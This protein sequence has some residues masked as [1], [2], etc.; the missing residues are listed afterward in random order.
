MAAS[1]DHNRERDADRQRI[2]IGVS[3]GDG[4]IDLIET[5]VSGRSAAVINIGLDACDSHCGT[6]RQAKPG[7]VERDYVTLPSGSGSSGSSRLNLKAVL[8]DTDYSEST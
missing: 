8:V 4:K 1:F 3:G 2:S 7:Q 5:E 6:G